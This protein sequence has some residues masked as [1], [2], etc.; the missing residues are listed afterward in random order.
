MRKLWGGAFGDESDSLVDRFGQSIESDL[1]FWREDVLGS[2][3]HAQM[4]GRTGILAS[5]ETEAIVA[6]LQRIL[7]EGP[8]SLPVDVEDIHT[9][10]E[11]RLGELVGGVAGKLHTARSRNDQVATDTRLF[12]RGRIDELIPAIKSL[13]GALYDTA[14]RHRSTVMPG[15]THQQPAQPIT[16]GLHQLGHFWAFQRVGRRLIHLRE[17]VNLSPMGSAAV[18]GTGFPID[19]DSTATALGFAAPIPNALDAT[20]DRSFVLDALHWAASAMIDLSRVAQELVLWSGAEY[21]FV[22]LADAVTTGS[23]IMPQKRNPDMAEL[24]RGRTGRAIGNWTAFAA[25]MKAL[26]LGYNRDTQDD[27]P[28]LFESLDLVADALGLTELMIRG[29]DW[30]VER[31]RD[32]ARHGFSTATDLAD[33]LAS[34]GMPFREAHE[35]V[36][37]LVKRCASGAFE[38]P[39][40]A[41]VLH[42]RLTKAEIDEA[43]RRL[44][45]ER[46]V[47][48]RNSLG[49]PGAAA[50]G[51][52]LRHA[53]KLL[54]RPGF[55]SLT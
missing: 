46:S 55:A 45:V 23:S 7:D 44:A 12:L 21:G 15:Y 11:V 31:M 6:G 24:I 22:R 37:T 16:L 2:I 14:R 34:T 43:L 30:Q 33:F 40:V 38:P 17:F 9:A 47:R 25:T 51:I 18:A 41:E 53:R 29:A 49:G 26:P 5:T 4:L 1:R 3:A 36:G 35:L 28:G 27:K 52:Q 48:Q 42:E 10:V 20:S 13:Q 39:I 19:R 32:A 8:D 50:I 54:Q